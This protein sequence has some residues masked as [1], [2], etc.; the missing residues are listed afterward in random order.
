M[1]SGQM[2]LDVIVIQKL[3]EYVEFLGQELV[4]EVDRRVQHT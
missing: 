1:L 2:R 4:G 3:A